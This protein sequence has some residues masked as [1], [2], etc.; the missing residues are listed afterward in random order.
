MSCSRTIVTLE[1]H[2]F[3]Q[4][5]SLK[6]ITVQQHTRMRKVWQAQPQLGVEKKHA[7]IEKEAIPDQA[8]P[9]RPKSECSLELCKKAGH[10]NSAFSCDRPKHVHTPTTTKLLCDA[11]KHTPNDNQTIPD[12]ALQAEHEEQYKKCTL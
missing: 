5:L 6:L 9:L 4:R 3:P 2:V 12:R 7:V 1:C 10:G 8:D 11:A